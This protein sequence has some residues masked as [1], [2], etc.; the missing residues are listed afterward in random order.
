MKAQMTANPPMTPPTIAPI[1]LPPPLPLPL[2]L[3]LVSVG[4]KPAE[5]VDGGSMDVMVVRLVDEEPEMDEE[6]VV[7]AAT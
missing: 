1:L 7:L 2:A 4:D 5:P 3:P 6:A